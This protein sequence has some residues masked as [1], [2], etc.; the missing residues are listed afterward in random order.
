V[1]L[2]LPAEG[3]GSIAGVGRRLIAVMIDWFSCQLVSAA[4]FSSDPWWTLGLFALL[5]ALTVGTLGCSPGHRL[6]GLQLRR[7]DGGWPGPVA[8]AIRTALL[9]LAV[10]ALIF[11]SDSRGLHDRVAGTVLVRRVRETGGVRT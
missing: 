10:P 1:R 2:G 4:F 9:C 3:P 7:L 5:H 8:A 6:L 11:D